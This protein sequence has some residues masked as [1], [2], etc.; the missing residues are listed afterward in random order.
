MIF[1]TK[2]PMSKNKAATAAEAGGKDRARKRQISP[3]KVDC[4]SLSV[5]FINV[6]TMLVTCSSYWL[7][8]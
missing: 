1:M 3:V 2:C 4:I 8:E 5:S 7:R 6:A